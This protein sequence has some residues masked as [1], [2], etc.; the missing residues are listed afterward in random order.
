[1]A[2]AFLLCIAHPPTDPAAAETASGAAVLM[3]DPSL[4]KI[5][6]PGA[7]LLTLIERDSIVD[8]PVGV[9]RGT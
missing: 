7:R 8:G 5:L 3:L 9:R 2:L 6:S 1:M 4:N